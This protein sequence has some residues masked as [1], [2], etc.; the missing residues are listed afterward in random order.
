[1]KRERRC[2][3]AFGGIALFH[4][5]TAAA[6]AGDAPAVEQPADIM[7]PTAPPARP[8]LNGTGRDLPMG[9]PLTDNGFLLGE[10]NYTLTAD[11]RI[12]IDARSLMPLLLRIL[13]PDVLQRIVNATGDRYSIS[14]AELASLGINL[15]Y[16]PTNFGLDMTVDPA[17]RPRQSISVMG[18]VD[19]VA[20]PVAVPQDFSAYLTTFVNADYVHKGSD[21][22]LADPNVIFDSAI[23]FKGFVLE[24]EASMQS[25]FRRE[26]TRLVYDDLRRTARYSLGDLEPISRGFSGSSPMAGA[27]IVRVYADLEPQKNIQPRGQRSFT[28]TR[29]ATVE[30]IVNGQSVQQARLNPGTYDIGDFPFAQGSND[31]RLII[32]DDGGREQVISFSIDFDRTLL[33]AGL[34]EFGFYAGV[35][36]PF[37]AGGRSYSGRPIASGF[38]RRGLTDEL[39][40][41]GNF[42]VNNRGGVAGAEVVWANPLGTFSF[43]LAGSKNQEIGSGYAANMGY[44]Y[45]RIGRDGNSRSLT[46]SL[47]TISRDFALP[48][49]TAA[50]NPY[51]YEFGVTYSQSLGARHYASVDAFHAI[52]RGARSD[53]STLRA[54]YG[55]RP[56]QR[57]LLTAEASYEDRDRNS[58]LG[59]RLSLT[60]R[61]D[62]KSSASG[63]MDTRRDR[64]RLSYQRS[65][66]TGVGSYNAAVNVDRIDNSTALNANFN[67]LTNRAEVGAAHLTSFTGGGQITDQRTS[68]RTAFS[69]AYAGG[70]IALSRPIYDSFAI[71]KPHA[72]LGKA[73]VYLDPRKDEYLAR[74]DALGAAVMP[75]LS[76]YAPRQMTY[77]VPKAPPGY[78]LGTGLLQFVPPY[79]SGYMVEIGSDYFVTSTGRLLKPDGTQLDLVAGYAYEQASPDREP[80]RMFTNRSGRFAVQGMRAGRWRIEMP[81]GGKTLVY[82][83]EI[84]KGSA[85]LERVGDLQPEERK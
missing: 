70:Q 16:N 49:A 18:G 34:T 5:C 62:R 28:L 78:D 21:P 53:Q 30:T 4:P 31:V 82:H 22:G 32:R 84:P 66:G 72:S 26:G 33:A 59:F 68:L 55:W 58:G 77:D 57:L 15:E 44:E 14:T 76:A 1:M 65:D 3:A 29:S 51:A 23:R 10:V 39:T 79:R 80:I 52:G 40:A 45:S 56:S 6:L 17:M 24:N 2:I 60:Y 37:T 43:N 11:D 27:S 48:G 19:P 9:G 47:Q 35:E 83:V 50:S 64:A 20:G 81:A 13:S 73:S 69:L 12:L 54:T 71:V 46:A 63:E 67:M 38:Y 25:R 61:F 42:Q 75:E 8:R 85:G 41:G 36:A 7:S 74:S